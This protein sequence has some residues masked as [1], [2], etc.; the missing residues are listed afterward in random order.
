[1]N[2]ARVRQA[3]GDLAG[4]RADYTAALRVAP[5]DWP[6]REAIERGLGGAR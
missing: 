1:V 3:L 6:D 2:R 4:A 5:P